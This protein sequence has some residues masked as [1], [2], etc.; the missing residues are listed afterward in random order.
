MRNSR[1]SSRDCE[2]PGSR[3]SKIDPTDGD[4]LSVDLLLVTETNQSAWENRLSVKWADQPLSVV[5]PAG[6]ILLKSFRNSDQDQVD[7][8]RL[9]EGK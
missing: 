7:I 9:R 2:N 6:L 8:R 5:D 3:V 4:F 1:L